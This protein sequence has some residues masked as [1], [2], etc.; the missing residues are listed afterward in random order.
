MTFKK[1]PVM[2]IFSVLVLVSV[3]VFAGE[4]PSVKG[5]YTELPGR[6]FKFDG[7]T[8][9]VIEFLSFY[10]H[11]CYNFEH[12]IPVIKGNFPK[13]I[14][15]KIIPIYWGNGSPKPGEAY[16]LAEEAGKG[17]EMKKALFNAQMIQRRDIGDIDVL[18]SI[19]VKSGLGFDFSRRLRAGDKSA[20]VKKGMEM[21]KSYNV[22]ETPTLVIAGNI[23]T[24]PDAVDHNLDALRANVIMIIKSILQ[25]S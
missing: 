5:L 9:E 3:S 15:W 16:L 8:V 23:M 14:R 21:A 7:K 17:E 11:T 22:T 10:C 1:M 19:G 20:E 12:S 24:S 13:K 4:K 25:S 18:E 6:Q 2:L